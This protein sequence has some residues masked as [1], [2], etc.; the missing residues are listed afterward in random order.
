MHALISYT[1][2]YAGV[3]LRKLCTFIAF[4][5]LTRSIN[6]YRCVACAMALSKMNRASYRSHEDGD[7]RSIPLV[8]FDQRLLDPEAQGDE[9]PFIHQVWSNVYDCEGTSGVL[10]AWSFMSVTCTLSQLSGLLP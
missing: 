9:L 3:G 10:S 2:G 1:C 5:N 7:Q 6:G 4:R 8:F